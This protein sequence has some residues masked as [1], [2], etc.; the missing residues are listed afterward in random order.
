MFI[1]STNEIKVF[2]NDPEKN[3]NKLS[4]DDKV[5]IFYWEL[6]AVKSINM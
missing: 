1:E 4:K 5:N 6:M 3:F 2:T